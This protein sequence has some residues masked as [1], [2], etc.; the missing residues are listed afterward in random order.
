MPKLIDQPAWRA[1]TRRPGSWRDLAAWAGA[2]GVYA[3]AQSLSAFAGR[4]GA[5]TAGRSRRRD[6]YQDFRRPWFAPPGPAFPVVWSALNLTTA[7]SAWRLWRDR[8]AAG[9]QVP[10]AQA[11]LT[12]WA[13]AVLLRSGYVPLAFGARRYWAAT[14][15]SALLC[16]VMAR[17]ATVARRADPAAAALAVPEIAWTAFATVLSAAIAS[18]N[19]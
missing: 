16:A 15:D 17:Y 10:Q 4:G 7:T 1:A 18:Q 11:A 12:W 5:N 3:A 19:A 9:P 13:L 2:A 14:V 6:R 8:R